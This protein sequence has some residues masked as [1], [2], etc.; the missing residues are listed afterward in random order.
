MNKIITTTLVSMGLLYGLTPKEIPEAPEN[1]SIIEKNLQ[2]LNNQNKQTAKVEQLQI[3]KN[4]KGQS[5]NKLKQKSFYLLNV[6]ITG[7]TIFPKE[8]IINI[9]KPYVSKKVTSQDLKTIAAKI[10]TLYHK[11]G[12]ITSKCIIPPQKVVNGTVWFKIIEDRLGKIA[13]VGQSAYNYNQN[14]FMR[15]LY[16]LQGKI[17]NIN[18]LNDRLKLL[19]N[20]PVTRITPK[21]QRTNRGFTILILKI[22]EAKQKNYVSIDNSGSKYTGI[23]RINIGG[24]INNIRGF[25]DSLSINVLTVPNPKYLGAVNFS[26]VTPFSDKGA[27]II[28]GYSNMYYQLNPDKVGTDTVIYSGTSE[29]KSIYFQ[30]PLYLKSMPHTNLVYKFGIENKKVV[31]KTTQNSDGSILIDGEDK[32]FVIAA[33]IDIAFADKIF[34]KYM[35]IDKLSLSVKRALEGVFGSMTQEDL[36]RKENDNT[37]PITGP[38]KYGNYLDPNFTK[39]YYS[40]SRDQKLK[41][42]MK[43]KI[44]LS[45]DYTKKR[46]PQSY[47]FAGHDWG[48]SYSTSLSKSFPKKFS[49]SIGVSQSIVYDYSTTGD[50]SK[51]TNKPGLSLSLSKQYK[52]L[53]MNLSYSTGFATWDT[54][55]KDKIRFTLKYTW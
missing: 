13:I 54:N 7:N 11:A 42:K 1:S 32:T 18:E 41:N 53:Y 52:N 47:E 43:W 3:D 40:F 15:Y 9:V 38:I 29:T 4:V 46:V 30:K 50:L 17:L 21:L 27:K 19:A 6:K 5:E 24:N 34:K 14:I 12:Y 39:L 48:F 31:S 2:E 8:D 25:S 36:K 55:P 28:F 51:E 16:D 37:F 10:T 45:G 44:S 33:G 22:D 49:A 20:L 35:A 23:Y 26:Y